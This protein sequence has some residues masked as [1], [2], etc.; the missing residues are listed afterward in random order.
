MKNVGR[1]PLVSDEMLTEIKSILSNLR[2]SRSA[3]TGK[4]AIVAIAVGNGVLSARCTEKK[5]KN[6][7]N[8]VLKS[9]VRVRWRAATAK[10][11]MNPAF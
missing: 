8:N 1:L 9:L 6:C 3:I 7:R 5:A 11:E 4:V 10:N 2:I